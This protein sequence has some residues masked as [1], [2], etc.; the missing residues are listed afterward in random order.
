MPFLLNEDQKDLVKLAKDFGEKHLKNSVAELDRKGEFPLEIYKA[1]MELGFHCLEIPEEYGG[2]GL[3]NLTA[4]A[5]Y[6]EL[7]KYDAGFA[8][9]LCATSLGLKPVLIA[10]TPEQKKLFADVVIPGRF[11]AFALTEPDAGSDAGS[12]LT[13][14]VKD[15]DDYI[16]N[17]KKCFITNAGFADIFVVF[18]SIDRSLGLK[19]ISAFIVE[20][21]TPGISVG[22]EEDKMGIRLSNTTDVF[23]DNVR[24]PKANLL[25]KEGEGFKIA[26][27]TLD[28][29]RP[30][31]G[32][33]ACGI[34][35]RAMEE[36]V[37]YSKERIQ[38]KKPIAAL[39]A[40]QFK[41]ADMAIKVETAEAM[42]EHVFRMIDMKMPYSMEAAV[43]KAYAGDIAV[44]VC[45]EA[46]QVL[47][48][49]GYSREYPVEKL[50]RDAKIFQIFEGTNE[51]QRVVI[52][53][54]LLR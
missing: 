10:G 40:I 34:A 33:I 26:M 24:V 25:G 16:I 21:S 4:A 20:R 22:K 28:L 43:A 35:R 53:G 13:V 27:L 14:A 7:G 54:T 44:E 1:A 48:G 23:F 42:L 15:G 19:G 41:L 36:A 30:F 18:A 17:G 11:G 46:I 6:E 38:F 9:T 8:T 49:Y 39:Q 47:G 3:D 29:A 32:A 37:K 2:G 5:I 51:V 50:L 45:L 52:A 12:G 31:V